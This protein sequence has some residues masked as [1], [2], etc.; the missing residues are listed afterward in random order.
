MINFLFNDNVINKSNLLRFINAMKHDIE[1]ARLYTTKNRGWEF[2]VKY[3]F[4]LLD[5][6][7]PYKIYK[8]IE[9]PRMKIEP[10]KLIKG[11]KYKD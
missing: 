3:V 4:D 7:D 8:K 2:H 6:K 5:G 11:G 1:L 9:E 10:L